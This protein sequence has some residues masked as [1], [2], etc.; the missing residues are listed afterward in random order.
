MTPSHGKGMRSQGRNQ[1]YF[2]QTPKPRI[3]L[4]TPTMPSKAYL[5]VGT[6]DDPLIR[7]CLTAFTFSFSVNSLATNW[8]ATLHDDKYGPNNIFDA[9]EIPS[10][11]KIFCA[12]AQVPEFVGYLSAKSVS[13]GSSVGQRS[14][15][16]SGTSITDVVNKFLISGDF[17][18]MGSDLDMLALG[19]LYQKQFAIDGGIDIPNYV[20]QTFDAFMEACKLGG[21]AN[22]GALKM[23]GDFSQGDAKAAMDFAGHDTGKQGTE[24]LKTFYPIVH[25]LFSNGQNSMV[26]CWR[27][28]MPDKF[29]EIYGRVDKNGNPRV[30]IRKKP[31]DR[32]D[33]EN[34][35]RVTIFPDVMLAGGLQLTRSDTEVYT[36]FRSYLQGSPND[37]NKLIEIEQANKADPTTVTLPDKF[38]FY[39]YRPLEVNFMGFDIHDNLAHEGEKDRYNS[40]LKTTNETLRDWYGYLDRMYNG[41][42]RIIYRYDSK[43]DPEHNLNPEA[44]G[45]IDLLGGQFYVED[46][47]HSWRYGET[48]TLSLK[49]SRGAVYDTTPPRPIE[50]L[51]NL[52]QEDACA[53]GLL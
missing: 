42:L 53:G 48:P 16:V 23:L 5:T 9:I 44:G 45:V 52:Y 10:V 11:V 39:G 28:V 34:Q 47:T 8:N 41:T 14:I 35:H 3:E 18:G 27:A 15:A 26:N 6:G 46:L 21:K 37:R 33:W 51:A 30:V 12:D 40:L 4:F 31:F 13:F 22:I 19:E 32:Q 1:A 38:E 50:K 25:L 29:Y 7:D 20:M 49:M 24:E 2:V 17:S 36:A 43:K